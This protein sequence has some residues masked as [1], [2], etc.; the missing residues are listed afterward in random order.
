MSLTSTALQICT[1][2][3]AVLSTIAALLLWNRVR[4]PKA[5]RALSRMV[6]LAGGYLT[7]AVAVLV[8]VNIAYGGLIV[9][10]SDLFSNLNPPQG[11]HFGHQ[12]REP[13]DGFEGGYGDYGRGG[14]GHAGAGA[15]GGS[16]ADSHQPLQTAVPVSR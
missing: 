2:V 13:A 12:G 16:V 1:I 3:I 14:S 8:S 9:S 10:V 15:G 4:G 11:P 6:L 7:A 5:V